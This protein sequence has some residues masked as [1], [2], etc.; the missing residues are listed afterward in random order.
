MIQKIYEEQLRRIMRLRERLNDYSEITDENYAD[1][2][3][4]CTS[5][6]IQCYHLSDWL[7]KSG[8]NKSG[9]HHYVKSKHSLSLCRNLANKQKHQSIDRYKSENRFV[10]IERS[11]PITRFVDHITDGKIKL[12][13]D[14]WELGHPIGVLEVA[15]QCIKDWLA[16]INSNV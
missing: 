14:L 11:T 15:D 4:D 13:I 8:F 1:A 5:F 9:V 10:T 12:G 2:I 3:D 6:F 7:I 16:F